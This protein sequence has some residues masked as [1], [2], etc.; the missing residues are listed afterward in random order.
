MS[1]LADNWEPVFT[2]NEYF[3]GPRK[4]FANYQGS[5]HAYLSEWDEQTDDW[6]TVY[7]LSPISE[8]QLGLAREDWDIFRRWASAHRAQSLTPDD[9]CPAL[10]GDWP[11]LK[12]LEPLVNG[13][14]AVDKRQAVRVIPEFRGTLEPIHDFKVRW[15]SA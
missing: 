3:D 10:A 11:R 1:A 2:V 6:K 12:Q 14:L 7:L 15:R 8:E 9:I 13:A 4:G 5:P